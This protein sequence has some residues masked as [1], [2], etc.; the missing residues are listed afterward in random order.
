MRAAALHLGVLGVWGFGFR[1]AAWMARG[2]T[3]KLL[4]Q[5]Q[6]QVRVFVEV[7]VV[8]IKAQLHVRAVDGF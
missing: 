7:F 4:G 5:V 1:S 8:G 6:V 2:A 3:M